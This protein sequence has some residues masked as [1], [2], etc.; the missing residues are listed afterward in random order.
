MVLDDTEVWAA[1]EE[2]ILLA[3]RNTNLADFF[4]WSLISDIP[5]A[6][7]SFDL[8][9]RFE[10]WILVHSQNSPEVIY[11]NDGSGWIPV[12]GTEGVQTQD[13][14]TIG[15]QVTFAYRNFL[16]VRNTGLTNDLTIVDYPFD[17]DVK[18]QTVISD[19]QGGYWIGDENYGLVHYQGEDDFDQFQPDGPISNGSWQLHAYGGSMYVA[20]GEL[21]TNFDNNFNNNG[22]SGIESNGWRTYEEQPEYPSIRD[23]VD[24]R[25]DPRAP[26]KKY[27]AAFLGGV[28]EYDSNTDDYVLYNQEEGNGNPEPS[29]LLP[30]RIQVGNLEFDINGNLWA[31]NNYT[32]TPFKIRKRDGEWIALG[33]S[34]ALTA[35]TLLGEMAITEEGQ[36]WCVL[37]RGAGLV[38]LQHN[39]DLENTDSHECKTF[40]TAIGDGALPTTTVF[41]VA[42]DLDGEIWLGTAEG[43][44]VN[45]NPLSIFSSNPADFQSI[46]IERDGNVERLLGSESITTIEIDGAN[47]KWIGTLTGGV[48]LLSPDG[49]QELIHF[50]EDNSPLFSNVI[51]DIEIDP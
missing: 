50:T 4:N 7:G 17:E 34:E 51:R 28:L 23:I 45:Y 42:E 14:V 44:V 3:D 20:H 47:R 36:T 38:L 16:Q 10:Q 6:T 35:S 11:A 15:D 21:K 5:S 19:G 46:L 41:A 25:I 27:F 40:S 30:D 48:F 18:P 12:G 39:N 26:N 22:F 29:S 31:T 33:C 43:P 1:T 32:D 37:P 9:E 8:I 24:V 49:T 2:G 13:I